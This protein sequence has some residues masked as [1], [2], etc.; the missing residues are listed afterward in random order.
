MSL[1]SA[2]LQLSAKRHN[3]CGAAGHSQGAFYSNFASKDDLLVDM[4]QT[5]IREEI[6]LLRDLVAQC[7]G[8]SIDDTLQVLAERLAALAAEPQWSLLSIELQLHARRD[9]DF[10]E[11]HREGKAS[12]YQVFTELI[13]DL[14]LRFGLRPV[15]PPHQ[16]GIGLYALWTGLAV[17]GDAAGVIP[18]EQML[19]GFFRAMAGL[20]GAQSERAFS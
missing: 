16:V 20:G 18:R 17:Q 1:T 12:C 5:H 11:R 13:T 4:L 10:A 2:F 8:A 19:V 3:I 15:L 9:P 6:A 7:E 14:T